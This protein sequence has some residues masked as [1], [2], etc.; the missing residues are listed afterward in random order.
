MYI[1][2]SIVKK[3]GLRELCKIY[4]LIFPCSARQMTY[5]FAYL[6]NMFHVQIINVRVLRELQWEVSRLDD[7]QYLLGVHILSS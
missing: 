4:T 2:V 3:I 5:I 1:H 7:M 6:Q